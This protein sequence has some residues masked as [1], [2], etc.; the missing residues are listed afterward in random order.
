MS[1]YSSSPYLGMLMYIGYQIYINTPYSIY[2]IANMTSGSSGCDSSGRDFGK[3]G[4]F[5]TREEKV[6]MLKEYKDDLEREVQGVTGRIKE[7]ENK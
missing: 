5:L 3:V 2:R 6:S 7:L 4:S 1:Q